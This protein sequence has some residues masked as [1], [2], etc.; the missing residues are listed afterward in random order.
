MADFVFRK[1]EDDELDKCTELANLAFG[2]D[3]RTLLPKVYGENPFMRASH[4]VADNGELKGLVAVLEDRL[5]VD[6]TVLKT[7][8]VGSVCVHPDTRRQ[9]LMKKLMH[10][11]NSGMASDG[12][13]IAFLSGK[14]QRYQYYGFVPAGVTYFFR[15]TEDNVS[16]ALGEVPADDIR[17]EE[18][19]SGSGF[20]SGAR[21]M[22]CSGPVYFERKEFAALCRS[23][24]QKPYAI[25]RS[26]AFIGYVVTN[27]DKNCW[28]EVCVE[29]TGALDLAVRAWMDQNKIQGLQIILPEWENALCRHLACYVSGMRRGYSV[30]ARIFR[31]KR[32]AQA[33]LKV[34]AR[35]GGISDGCMAFDIEGERFEITVKDGNVLV[36]EGG[37]NPLRLTAYEANRLMLLPF[38]YE[39]MPAA[40]K[41]WFPLI[42]SVAPDAPDAF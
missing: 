41:D 22:Y 1:A 4:Y 33:Y 34:K 25:L 6:E 14:R 32:V 19:D 23:Y 9:G 16:H 12:T 27:R 10:L 3:F 26:G 5:A 31:F 40:P 13:D 7:G 17:F 28:G 39:G 38:P 20:E 18:I 42:V 8:Y 21:D 24:H 11:A 15:V 36:C 35:I 2:C 37:E 29:D 30:Q